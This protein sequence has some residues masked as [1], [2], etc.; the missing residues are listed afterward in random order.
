MRKL[1]TVL[2]LSCFVGILLI[3]IYLTVTEQVAGGWAQ[4]KFNAPKHVSYTGPMFIVLAFLFFGVYFIS[5]KGLRREYA[6]ER[7]DPNIR[8]LKRSATNRKR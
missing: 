6:E 7:Q 1:A 3:G 2:S 5:R 4:S 8:I